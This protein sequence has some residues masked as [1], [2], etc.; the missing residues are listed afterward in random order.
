V[1][2]LSSGADWAPAALIVDMDGVLYRGSAALP[3]LTEFACITSSWPRVLLTNN[4]TVSAAACAR[5]LRRLGVSVPER[6]ILTV[7]AAMT[8]YLAAEF[9]P[10]T[11]VYVIGERPLHDAVRA[12][13]LTEEGSRPAAVVAGLDRGL[14]YAQLAEATGVLRAGR[15][16]IVTS[17]DP[18]LLTADGV[19][20]GAGAIVAALR[21]CSGT[22]P[23]CVGKPEPGFFRG[24]L[25]RLG[26]PADRVL[27]VGDSLSADVA[28]GRAAGTRTALVLSGVTKA[29]PEG[30]GPHPD[31]VFE[32][33]AEL[34]GFLRRC[35]A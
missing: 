27:V 14:R 23:V 4:S 8:G 22:K 33:L 17:L 29:A 15:P 13:R 3:G 10:G 25:R 20:P 26:A 6:E 1:A 11:S 35:A 19:V 32:S 9:S 18:V 12:A 16:L 24:A 34:N 5:K 30:P 2:R 21:A 31:Y 7:S 28:G